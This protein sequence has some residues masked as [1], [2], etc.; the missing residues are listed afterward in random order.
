MILW[1]CIIGVIVNIY[2]FLILLFM[3]VFVFV[4][5]DIINNKKYENLKLFFIYL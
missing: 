1:F 2:V 4:Y 3:C 5:F